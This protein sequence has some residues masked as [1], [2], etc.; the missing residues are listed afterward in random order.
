MYHGLQQ[1]RIINYKA[2]KFYSIAFIPPAFQNQTNKLNTW[3]E[4]LFMKCPLRL[5]NVFNNNT[6]KSR[7]SSNNN[8]SN[9]NKNKA[10]FIFTSQIKL[11]WE[12]ES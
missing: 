5:K 9:N 4:G 2:K 7:N 3:L 11:I 12:R 8:S 1:S 10:V 6:N